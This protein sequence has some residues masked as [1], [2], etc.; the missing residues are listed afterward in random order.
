MSDYP[1]W[2]SLEEK[3]WPQVVST[4]QKTYKIPWPAAWSP[5][6]PLEDAVEWE[7]FRGVVH[8]LGEEGSVCMGSVANWNLSSGRLAT[9]GLVLGFNLPNLP[10]Y[11]GA[12]SALLAREPLLCWCQGVS[13]LTN[14]SLYSCQ[15][16]ASSKPA[17][18]PQGKHWVKDL[19]WARE[20]WNWPWAASQKLWLKMVQ[21]KNDVPLSCVEFGSLRV[22]SRLFDLLIFFSCG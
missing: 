18:L 2:T 1:W 12:L 13:S 14:L 5:C 19:N 15:I 10:T 8:G 21:G 16:A 4:L 11:F 7:P 17:L 6:K 9:R 20:R 3:L 22:N